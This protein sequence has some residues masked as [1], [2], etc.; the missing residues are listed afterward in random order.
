MSRIEMEVGRP[1]LADW[2]TPSM[3][4]VTAPE[5]NGASAGKLRS[6]LVN[7]S[8]RPVRHGKTT[9]GG[10]AGVAD[11][12]AVGESVAVSERIVSEMPFLAPVPAGDRAKDCGIRCY[13]TRLGRR[14]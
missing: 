11:G 8:S 14:R 12:D 4:A 9:S 3:I 1:V 6:S 2:V 5:A 13:I 10:G 7:W